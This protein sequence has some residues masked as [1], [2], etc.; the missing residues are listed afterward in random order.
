MGLRIQRRVKIGKKTHLNVSN[1]GVSGSVK[2][3]RL[4]LNSRG[5]NSIRI[6][7]GLSFKF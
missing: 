3:G 2:I 1:S 6:A 5:R 7:K 4:T